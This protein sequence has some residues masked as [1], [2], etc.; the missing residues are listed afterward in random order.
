MPPLSSP[1]ASPA[2]VLP[3]SLIDDIR[4]ILAGR[5]VWCP[6]PP[7]V[8]ALFALRRQEEFALL[9]RK[10]WPLLAL[11]MG[12]TTLMSWLMF[13]PELQGS[14]GVLW[15]RGAAL[16]GLTLGLIV[17]LM[18]HPGLLPHYQR[19]VILVGAIN[20]A[21]PLLGTMLLD[22]PRLMQATSYICLLV[23]NIQVLALR[24]S[25][26]AAAL[27]I[28]SG[29]LLT[30]LGA[31]YWQAYPDWVMLSWVVGSSVAVTF[32][33]G[34]ILERQERIIFL[35]G[36]LLAH[37]S[38]ERERLNRKLARLAHQDGLSGLANRRHFDLVLKH[39]WER[40]QREQQPLVLLFI[41]VDYFKLYNDTYGHVAGD[42]CLAAIG[43]ILNSA[44]RRPGDVAARY[45]GEEFVVLLSATEINGAREVA[46]RIIADIDALAIPHSSSSV[47]AHVT[48]SV[49]L[50]MQVPKTDSSAASL[51]AQADQALYAAKHEG[52][53]RLVVAEGMG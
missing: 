27:C 10:A 12:M 17:L 42:E 43:Q 20:L 32:F 49:G 2:I 31:F 30:A 38:G 35:Q 44:V 26:S 23:I 41:D 16:E 5:I 48:V 15:W 21:I 4:R 7:P 37:E 50:A 25:L 1:T 39:E 52:R 24:L 53:H 9:A 51:L 14:D 13:G 18:H 19:I 8:N 22:S 29:F 33:I 6:L 46:E 45:G 11:L 36:L 28:L 3:A 34:A 40:L 47:S